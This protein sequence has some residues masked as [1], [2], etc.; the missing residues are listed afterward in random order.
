MARLT[1]TLITYY[2]QEIAFK[3]TWCKIFHGRRLWY[4][5]LFGGRW[6]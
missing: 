2:R 3:C 5:S 1:T 4:W 6:M